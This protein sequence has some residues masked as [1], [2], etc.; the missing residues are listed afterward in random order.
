MDMKVLL[1]PDTR[2]IAD[3]TSIESYTKDVSDKVV[4]MFKVMYE[5]KGIGLAAPQIGW[6]VKL[7]I[8]NVTGDS[9]NKSDERIYYNPTMKTYGELIIDMEGCLSFPQMAAWIKRYKEIE[10]EAETPTGHIKETFIDLEA[11]AI[12]HE[13]DHLNGLLFIEKMTPADLRRNE[14]LLRRMRGD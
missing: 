13:I 2:L 3:N 10:L 6:N 12:Q 7:F 8:M 11:R 1:Y 14:P 5:T 9:S 4:E